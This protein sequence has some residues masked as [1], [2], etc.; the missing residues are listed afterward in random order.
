MDTKLK[1]RTT[2]HPKIDGQIEVVNRTIIHILHGYC[3]K[4]PKIWDENL[5]YI[6][7]AYNGAKNS[8]TQ[9][10]PFEACF[11]YL[12]KS[13]LDFIFGKDVAIDGHYDIDKAKK[14]IEQIQ[15]VHQMVQEQLEKS[16]AKYKTRHDKFHVGLKGTDPRKAR[17]IEIGKVRELYPHLQID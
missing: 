12:P 6:Q 2:F 5:H 1:N 15:L 14:F 10:Y 3:N 8:F 11:G 16:Q 13:P 4:H 17:W 9:T 7:H